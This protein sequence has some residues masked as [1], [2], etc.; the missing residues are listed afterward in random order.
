MFTEMT[1]ELK[2]ERIEKIEKIERRQNCIVSVKLSSIPF[3]IL[4]RKSLLKNIFL[5]SSLHGSVVNEPD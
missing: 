1:E 4:C 2:I 3:L 5:G